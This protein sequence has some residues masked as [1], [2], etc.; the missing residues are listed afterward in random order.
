MNNMKNVYQRIL[1]ECNKLIVGNEAEIK[2]IVMSILSGGHVLLEAA[3]GTGKTTLVKTISKTL[4][5]QFDRI[6]FVSDLMPS[7]ILGVNVYNQKE[8]DFNF[9]KG[10]IF[11]NLLLA[12]EI[13]RAVPRTQSALL[14][15]MEEHQVTVDGNRYLL[16][17]PFI[18]IATQNPIEYES[19]F[20]LPLAQLD[21][22]FCKIVLKYPTKEK[23]LYM[24][25][26]LKFVNDFGSI[27]N[28]VDSEQLVQIQ[29]QS[30]TV[31]T[32]REVLTY[33]IE[34]IH[35]TRNRKEIMIGASPRA[36]KCL[37]HGA[38]IWAMMDERDFVTPDDVQDIAE[39]I[40]AH[41]LVMNP[42]SLSAK[43]TS[44]VIVK[45]II[46]EIRVKK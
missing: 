28:V 2:L 13:N 19:T 34:L 14:E 12:D 22:F 39:Q 44:D 26:H 8:E 21:R 16:P 17:E 4:G 43:R 37:L 38:K 23:E 31:Y 3:P 41:R 42:N 29:K 18:V 45:E 1:Q 24:I 36:T 35:A 6:Q 10:P 9:R 5:L 25:E 27:L 40:L 7:D 11:T 30:E 33:V 15:A 46:E 32:S 20:R